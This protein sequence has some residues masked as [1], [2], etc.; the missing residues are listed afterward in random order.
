MIQFMP[1]MLKER[2]AQAFRVSSFLYLAGEVSSEF[3]SVSGLE[4]LQPSSFQ[5]EV[6]TLL[7]GE[8]EPRS[9]QRHG[10]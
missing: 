7:G 8:P 10:L 3:H 9:S 5:H 1:K 2:F 6:V 4:L